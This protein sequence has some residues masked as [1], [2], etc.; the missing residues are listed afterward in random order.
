MLSWAKE[1]ALFSLVPILALQSYNCEDVDEN[2][3]NLSAQMIC[4]TIL[5]ALGDIKL[6][7]FGANYLSP[8]VS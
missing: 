2:F 6:S 3:Q 1:N 7:H 8:P 4:D 5:S